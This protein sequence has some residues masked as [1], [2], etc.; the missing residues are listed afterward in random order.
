MQ[1]FLSEV[2]SAMYQS[3]QHPTTKLYV[4]KKQIFTL[5]TPVKI[6]KKALHAYNMKIDNQE[7]AFN[8]II[9]TRKTNNV[10]LP[11]QYLILVL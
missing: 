3:I 8:I 7:S 10:K 5:L 6:I 11:M 2:Q 4:W 9:Y 1:Y